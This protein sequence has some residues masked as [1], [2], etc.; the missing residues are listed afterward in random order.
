MDK[1]ASA[2]VSQKRNPGELKRFLVT[3]G[4]AVACDTCVYTIL[5][6]FIPPSI[7]KAISFI[8]GTVLAFFLNKFWTFKRPKRSHAE[9]VKFIVLY[10]STL[11]ANVLVNRLVLDHA[12]AIIPMLQPYRAEFA[13]LSATGTS[14]V[15]NF[16]GQ[17]FWVFK[18]VHEPS[19]GSKEAE[20]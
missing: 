11:G 5:F 2:P 19:N 4:S 17:K 8:S 18:T 14:T 1:K 3:G 16:L 10:A 20:L 13:F 9:V 12:Q 6:S 15:L 7:A